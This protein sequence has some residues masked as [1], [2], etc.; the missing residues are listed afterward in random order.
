MIGKTSLV[1]LP[2]ILILVVEG[3]KVHCH[4]MDK[5]AIQLESLFEKLSRE[6]ETSKGGTVCTYEKRNICTSV[7]E[8]YYSTILIA[9]GLRQDKLITKTK[10]QV[11]PFK[12]GPLV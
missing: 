4:D 12:V 2:S 10:L 6:T 3:S 5:Q 11:S 7:Q 9:S 8:G 1:I